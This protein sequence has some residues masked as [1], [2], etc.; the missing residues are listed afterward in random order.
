MARELK[1]ELNQDSNQVQ[2]SNP[3]DFSQDF[4]VQIQI[5]TEM[6]KEIVEIVMSDYEAAKQAKNKREYARS[7]KGESVDF[8]KWF[9]DI[10]DLYN[11]NRLPKTI[12]WQFCS[13]RSL[14]IAA[15]ILDTMH[16]RLF[17]AV[18][19]ED[20]LKWRPGEVNDVPKV[21]RVSK[22]MHWWL[23]VRSRMRSTFDNW[24]KVIT[25]YGE[26]LTESSWKAVPIDMGKTNETPIIGPEGIP[27][28]NPDGTPAIQKERVIDLLES[29]C[30]Q[31]YLPDKFF[32]QEGSTDIQ[33]EPVILE[34]TKCFRELEDGEAQ[35][36][37]VNVTNLLRSMIPVQDEAFTNLPPEEREKMK[38]IKIRNHPVTFLKWYGNFDAD[39]DG[40]AEDIRVIVVP[41]YRLY[42]G[43]IPLTKI[44][45]SGKRP[46]DYTKFDSRI[47]CPEQ[48]WGIGVLEKIKELAEEIDAIFNQMTDGNTLSI[49][50][51]FFYDPGG[52]ADA[53]NLTLAPNKGVPI[54]NPSQNV[55][56][57]QINIQV[58]RLIN[59]IRLVLEFIE[60]LTAASSYI[61]GKESEIVGGSGTATRT[62]AIVQSA[63][64][65]FALPAERLREGAA[66]ISTQHLDLLQL[67]I[68]PGLERRILGEKGEPLFEANELSQQGIAGELD[69]YL[70][71]DPSMGSSQTARDLA[72]MFYSIFTQNPL[73][74]SDPAKFYQLSADVFKAYNKENDIPRILGPEPEQDMIDDPEDENTLMIQGNFKSVKASIAEN[75]IYHI[76]KHGELVQSPSLVEVGANAP[77]LAKQVLL[78]NQQHIQEHMAML[79]QVMTLMKGAGGKGAKGSANSGSQGSSTN[80]GMAQ[81]GGPLG[82]ALDSKREGEGGSYSPSQ[83]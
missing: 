11:A 1:D 24:V 74:A 78:F 28:T 6:E 48:N 36:K 16:S 64:Q 66:R 29:T 39:N 77:E 76:M 8:D 58:E 45:K 3:Q 43:G 38:S 59:A 17:P 55:F 19:N 54:S 44:T 67:N 14:R 75:H 49:L 70:L 61:L 31:V 27:L 26:S 52:D 20:L 41:E 30:S 63:E 32:L 33:R 53:P 23:W 5:S 65:R 68:P 73:V 69:A 83:P 34:D 47:E 46:L 56:F 79:Q 9:K 21:E 51:P 35:Q 60:R 2:E 13:N 4:S 50:M 12:P 7:S 72:G 62:N 81:T 18:I 57:P 82:T 37:Y 42:I 40:F 25:G 15:A 80:E 22:L 10:K 71:P